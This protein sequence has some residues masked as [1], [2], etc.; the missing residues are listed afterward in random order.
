M[1]SI[2]AVRRSRRAGVSE[3]LGMRGVA[4][5][6]VRPP[7]VAAG[8]LLVGWDNVR[9]YVIQPIGI[10]RGR[11]R[12]VAASSIIRPYVTRHMGLSR[13]PGDRKSVV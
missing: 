13:A 6:P 2:G 1:I 3:R 5:A 11:A 4:L 7:D 8:G 9:V 10:L 12:D